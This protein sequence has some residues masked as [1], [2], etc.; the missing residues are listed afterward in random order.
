[1][2]WAG[3]GHLPALGTP[4]PFPS[5]P[6]ASPARSG[7]MPPR[8]FSS[9]WALASAFSSLWP[10]TTPST[11]TATGELCGHGAAA[12]MGL[13]WARPRQSHVPTA[14]APAARLSTFPHFTACGAGRGHRRGCRRPGQLSRGKNPAGGRFLPRDTSA[15]FLPSRDALV[16]SAVNCLTSFL[17]GFVI[18]TVLGYMAEMRDVEVEDVARDKGSPPS[19]CPGPAVPG[20]ARRGRGGDGQPWGL[21]GRRGSAREPFRGGRAA[22]SPAAAVSAG[23][24]HGRSGFGASSPRAFPPPLAPGAVPSSWGTANPNQR[25]FLGPSL[26]FITYPEAIAN[27]VGSTFFAIIFFLMMITLGLDSTV[28][29]SSPAL[30]P[31][32]VS[33]VGMGMAVSHGKERG[34][35]GSYGLGRGSCL[36]APRAQREGTRW[37]VPAVLTGR[38]GYGG[39]RFSWGAGLSPRLISAPHAGVS[40]AVRGLGGCDHGRDGRVPPGPGR[41][42]GALRPRPHHG[43]F[44]G[45]AEHPHLREYPRAPRPSPPRT[46]SVLHQPPVRDVA[47]VRLRVPAG[48]AAALPSRV[49]SRGEPTW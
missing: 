19:S 14:P 3:S 1:M 39:S 12:G 42:A 5:P 44:P 7:L 40:F 24:G 47:K 35:E 2:G 18:F 43:L 48:S 36:R 45:L 26:L 28:G 33:P 37:D 17:S 38:G 27:M 8:R 34:E 30:Q 20:C 32:A 22:R 41:A 23:A 16:T 21:P 46:L 31:G 25:P 4:C 10:V 11:T 49:S 6:V 29:K 13:R 9:P 15:R